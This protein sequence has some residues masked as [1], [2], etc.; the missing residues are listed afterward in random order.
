MLLFNLFLIIL[1]VKNYCE[2]FENKTPH[3]E[4]SQSK[5]QYRYN[6]LSATQQEDL[7]LIILFSMV[8]AKIPAKKKSSMWTSL[9]VEFIY[10]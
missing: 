3:N 10:S 7:L 1:I 4:I 9:L 5:E 8:P 2:E 6:Q